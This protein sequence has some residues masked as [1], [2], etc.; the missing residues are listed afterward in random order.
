MSK[1]SSAP[2][3]GR[4]GGEAITNDGED[5]GGETMFRCRWDGRRDLKDPKE[6]IFRWRL[7]T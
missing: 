1:R 3:A 5:R 6:P 4:E 2:K 7:C